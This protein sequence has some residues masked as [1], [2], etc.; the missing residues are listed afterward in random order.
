MSQI[1]SFVEAMFSGLPKTEAAVKARLQITDNMEE[2]YDELMR[3]G[4]NADEALGIVIGEFGTMDEIKKELGIE[5]GDVCC[6][7]SIGQDDQLNQLFDEYKSFI[8]TCNLAVAIAAALFILSA[9]VSGYTDNPMLFFVFIAIG[10]GILIYYIGRKQDYKSLI[11]QR[12]AELGVRIAAE[13]PADQ[14]RWQSIYAMVPLG[15]VLIFLIL[16]I[17]FQ[18]WHPGWIVFLLIPLLHCVLNIVRKE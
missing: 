5:E 13:A 17:F 16:G 1:S 3:E 7:A 2:K 4:K 6:A 15:A 8:P 11:R 12:Q 9:V 10:V 14:K 18:L